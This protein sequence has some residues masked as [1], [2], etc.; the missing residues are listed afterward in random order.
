MTSSCAA[1]RVRR[2][3]PRPTSPSGCSR[4]AVT[5]A[6]TPSPVRSGV[7]CTTTPQ[8]RRHSSACASRRQRRPSSRPRG[9]CPTRVSSRAA[10]SIVDRSANSI[11]RSIHSPIIL[12]WAAGSCELAHVRATIMLVKQRNAHLVVIPRAFGSA[13]RRSQTKAQRTAVQRPPRRA[14]RPPTARAQPPARR[15]RARPRRAKRGGGCRRAPGDPW[16][17]TRRHAREGLVRCG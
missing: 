8:R 15:Q 3:S 9:T 16:C 5:A 2:A 7:S 11:G 6:R 1:A 10:N 14:S 17:A 4:G 12:I 13:P